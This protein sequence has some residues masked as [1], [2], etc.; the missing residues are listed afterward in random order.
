M[1]QKTVRIRFR[2]AITTAIIIGLFFV[3]MSRI[4]YVVNS[5]L[6]N[7]GLEFSYGWANTYW[8]AY[9]T[10]FVI[11]SAMAGFIYWF[12]SEKT[13]CDKKV[14][15]ALIVTGR[16]VLHLLGRRIAAEQ[17]G[18]VVDVVERNIRNMEHRPAGFVDHHGAWGFPSDLGVCAT[19]KKGNL[20][21]PGLTR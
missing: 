13:T 17:R 3:A 16:H 7:Y 6:Y 14:A 2:R 10:V 4:D 11:F 1:S 12:G 21:V 5:T 20:P 15:S 8:V 9:N 19:S 18:L